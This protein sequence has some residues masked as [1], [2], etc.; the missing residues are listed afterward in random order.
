MRD[1]LRN[2]NE[3]LD[4]A[5]VF[6][7]S[8]RLNKNIDI[9]WHEFYELEYIT[10]GNGRA[11]INDRVYDLKPGTLLFLSPVDFEKIEVESPISL[12]NL[13]FSG[14]LISSKINPLL[15][16][17]CVL[18]DYPSELFNILLEEARINDRWYHKK[19]TQLVNCVLIDIVRE[20]SK[21]AET[22]ELSPII[23]ALRFMELNFRNHIT[24][25]E[26]S[27]HVGFT[28]NYFSFL[29]HKETNTTFKKHLAALRLDYAAKLLI[30]SDFS[31]TEICYTAGFN[32]FSGFSR[33]F[34]KRF[35]M[36]PSKYRN[37]NI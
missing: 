9:H 10:E 30:I 3:T 4:A 2:T 28:P 11:Y 29:F 20:S 14:A 7:I 19:Y 1:I 15:S 31:S 33:A 18:Y 37:K 16:G 32:D 6:I 22:S 23:K 24:L 21:N 34:K 27:R 12:V 5:G 17:G 35:S 8:N 13:A 36:S 26:I 25:E